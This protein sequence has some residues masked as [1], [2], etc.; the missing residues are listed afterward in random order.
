MARPKEERPKQRRRMC[1]H[2]PDI[3]NKSFAE[4]TK[5]RTI[6]EVF[7]VF[8]ASKD[9]IPKELWRKVVNELHGSFMEEIRTLG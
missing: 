9:L 4:G 8:R 3:T 2:K 7:E 6:I 5:G 1:R